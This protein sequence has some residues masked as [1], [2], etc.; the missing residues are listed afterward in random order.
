MPDMR[1][2]LPEALPETI[3]GL[4][5]LSGGESLIAAAMANTAPVFLHDSDVD[6]NRVRSAFAVALHM[7]QPLIPAGTS[8]LQSAPIISNLRHMMEHPEIPDAHNAIVFR[9]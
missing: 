6:F 1:D 8:E 3:D 4:P 7:H 5:N 2:S 9:E